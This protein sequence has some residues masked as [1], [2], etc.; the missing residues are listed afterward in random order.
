MGM[1]LAA[2]EREGIVAAQPFVMAPWVIKRADMACRQQGGGDRR[3]EEKS[4]PLPPQRRCS[5]GSVEDR[6][7]R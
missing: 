3:M 4:D 2:L 1:V 5:G 7:E 6:H